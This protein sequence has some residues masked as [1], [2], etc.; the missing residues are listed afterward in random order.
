MRQTYLKVYK[1]AETSKDYI[2]CDAQDEFY[3]H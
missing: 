3:L 1:L 2:S